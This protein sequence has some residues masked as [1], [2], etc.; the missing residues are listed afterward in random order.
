MLI[1]NELPHEWRGRYNEDTDLCLQVL[2]D[3]WCT[4][5]IQVF[6]IHKKQTMTMKGGNTDQLYDGD[7]RLYM[8]RSLERKWPGVVR[9]TRKFK[10]P[11]HHIYANWQHFDN[12]LIR[13]DDIDFDN[14]KPIDEYGLNLKQI[15]PVL[16]SKR[17]QGYIDEQLLKDDQNLEALGGS[18][19]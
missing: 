10:R 19:D 18:D 14:L 5:Q 2:A 8:A 12:K 1:L 17:L 7:G 16:R 4:I 15:K 6:L 3:G 13:R 9:T 11:Q